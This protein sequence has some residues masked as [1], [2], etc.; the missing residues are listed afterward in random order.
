MLELDSDTFEAGCSGEAVDPRFADSSL[1]SMTAGGD[2]GLV[3]LTFDEIGDV[4]LVG[5]QRGCQQGSR[6]PVYLTPNTGCLPPGIGPTAP[7]GV[8]PSN[9]EAH[10]VVLCRG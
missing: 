9:G 8:Q 5:D 4:I 10:P 2:K 6:V 7:T 1:S 3:S